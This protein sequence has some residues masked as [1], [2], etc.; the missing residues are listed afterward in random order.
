MNTSTTIIALALTTTALQAQTMTLTDDQRVIEALV[1]YQTQDDQFG[2]DTSSLSPSKPFEHW[3]D[4]VGVDIGRAS[5]SAAL[6]STLTETTMLTS[7]SAITH[8]IHDPDSSVFTIAFATSRHI[9]GF[10]ISETTTFALIADLY[11]T[12]IAETS[13]TIRQDNRFGDLLYEYA[14]SEGTI[15]INDQITLDAGTYYLEFRAESDIKLHM[16]ADETGYA[17]FDAA[18]AVVPAPATSSLLP[19]AGLLL[20]ARRRR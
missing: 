19:I 17:S 10:D 15:S 3:S 20:T 18:W 14:I 13:I 4:N 5:A 12:G 8:A 9:I 2:F 16:P 7:S 1:E 11:V 6:S